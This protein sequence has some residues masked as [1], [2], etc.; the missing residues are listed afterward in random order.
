MLGLQR[1][2]DTPEASVSRKHR[3]AV[4]VA[5][6]TVRALPNE[7]REVR[8]KSWE[9][10]RRAWSTLPEADVRRR[11]L[12][13][14]AREFQR[15]ADSLAEYVILQ[16]AEDLGL[17]RAVIRDRNLQAAIDRLDRPPRRPGYVEQGRRR[18]IDDL[19]TMPAGFPNDAHRAAILVDAL[20]VRAVGRQPKHSTS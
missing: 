12:V 16:D 4:K 14:A 2:G 5:A 8:K 17:L 6:R 19:T 15:A 18:F 13:E 7:G 10:L 1:R 3:Q 11:A 9:L 20:G